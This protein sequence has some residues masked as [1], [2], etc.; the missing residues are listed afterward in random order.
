M[1]AALEKQNIRITGT[2][3][4]LPSQRHGVQKFLLHVEQAQ[5]NTHPVA[6]HKVRL[7]WYQMD[8]IVQVGERYR[9]TVRLRTPRN[10]HNPGQYDYARTQWT[11]GIQ[12]SGYVYCCAE[13][14]GE[15]TGPKIWLPRLR[16]ALRAQ[17]QAQ[18]FEHIAWMQALVLGDRSML[19]A[20][21]WRLMR[22]SGIGHLLAISGL[23][24][25][26]VAGFAYWLA[27][28]LLRGWV[29][30]GLIATI[31]PW[32]LL[33]SLIVAWGYAL[34]SGFQL[35]AQRAI[36]MLSVTILLL[37]CGRWY[38]WTLMFSAA[39]AAVLLRDPLAA[40]SPGFWLSFGAV[41]LLLMTFSGRIAPHQRLAAFIYRWGYPQWVLMLGLAPLLLFFWHRIPLWSLPLNLLL[42][43]WVGLVILPWLLAGS[44]L[45]WFSNTLGTLWL[46]G[47]DALLSTVTTLL[48]YADGFA[49]LQWVGAA[50]GWWAGGCAALALLWIFA[51]LP[52]C[53]KW[54]S[55]LL[56]LPLWF[57]RMALPPAPGQA[58]ITVLDVGQGLAV[59]VQTHRHHLLYDSG[60]RS[61]GGFDIGSIV[62]EPYL[63]GQGIQ[64]VDTMLLSH[65][66]NDHAGGAPY[67][68]KQIRFDRL[69]ANFTLPQPQWQ[70][71]QHASCLQG[72]DW[73]WDG[74]EFRVLHPAQLAGIEEENARSCVLQI[75]VG[76]QRVLL[77]GDID[78]EIEAQLQQ[79]WGTTLA[80]G[81]LVAPHHGSR[82][83]SSKAFIA[84]VQPQ[85]VVFSSGYKN[86]Y[87][88][89]HPQVV[90][91]YLAAGAEVHH[92]AEQGAARYLVD[93]NGIKQ[94]K[95]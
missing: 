87:G 39:L 54:P 82:S 58:R 79:S 85:M 76:K 8:T 9:M 93:Y 70:Q 34:L 32:N 13:K 22:N 49:P 36:I 10:L 11:R 43:P 78:T 65:Q 68:L 77:S 64:R 21:H 7:S 2:V 4:S 83:S 30:C 67:L 42:V 15:I 66:D 5:W 74:V 60:R 27:N 55:L 16:T 31:H 92:T 81:L 69:L 23:H 20:E 53:Y 71:T 6:L 3:A 88:H 37:L 26:L 61:R 25:A 80:S 56:L 95:W 52:L 1:D 46:R 91:R 41:G 59:H 12:A 44:G 73:N 33:I 63:L 72:Q 19:D 28:L 29:F 94:V 84:A 38:S 62:I 51:P 17:L 45:L 18:D 89:P 50:P 35:P 57:P 75:I 40:F 86:R 24:I 90:K 14:L 47:G 48:N